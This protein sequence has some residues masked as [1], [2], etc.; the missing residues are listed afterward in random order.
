MAERGCHVRLSLGAY[1][2]GGL[3]AA[4]ADAVRKHLGSCIPCRAEHDRLAYLPSWLSLLSADDFGG[5]SAAGEG[6][7]NA[8]D[9]GGDQKP[10][11]PPA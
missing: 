7:E 6:T 11:D 9:P 5:V 3:P 2:L 8:H 1:L 4:E 10:D